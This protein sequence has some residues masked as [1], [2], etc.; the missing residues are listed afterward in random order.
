[1][2]KLELELIIWRFQQH[3]ALM[4][5]FLAEVYETMPTPDIASPDDGT[6]LTVYTQIKM[7]YCLMKFG[8]FV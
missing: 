2:N 3:Q 6:N 4:I 7:A 1:M 8:V 5:A